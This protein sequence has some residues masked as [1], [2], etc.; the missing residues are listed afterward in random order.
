MGLKYVVILGDGMADY[1]V[2]SLGGKTPLAAAAIPHMDALAGAGILGLVQ[3]VPDG[4]AP[5]S[6]TANLAVLGYDPCA[7]FSGRSPFE[8]A[9]MG[10]ALGNEDITFRC[11]LVT[12]SEGDAYGERR[13]LDHSADE[14]STGE[15]REL[16]ES[17]RQ[18]FSDGDMTFYPG[19]SYRHLLVW[20]KG[21]R[22]WLLT[23]PHD[24]LGQAVQ[25]YLPAGPAAARV[26]QMM[27][28]SAVFL[29]RHPVNIERVRRGLRPANSIWIWGEGVKPQIPLFFEKYGIRGGVISAVDLIKGIGVCAGLDVIDVPGATGNLHTD[30]RGKA[31]AAL[32]A[33][34]EGLDFVY[35]HIEAPDEC[36]HRQETENKVKAIELIDS[37]TLKTLREG[38]D[39]MGEPYKILLLPDHATPLAVRTHTMDAV[40]F[41]IFDSRS[42]QPMVS[43]GYDEQ[44]AADAGLFIREGYRLMD[45]FLGKEVDK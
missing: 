4:M 36:G 1:P 33:L 32:D 43:R 11:N 28:E 42:S 29:P 15:A 5:G 37:L 24:I 20:H 26:L 12:I 14:I 19:V 9:S 16:I 41:V 8:A 3:T 27:E 7:Y 21:P 40:P 34:E 35:I 38:L 25:P 18:H 2:E 22:E 17:V 6:D 44:A 13:M 23:P 30:F 45:L 39:Q 10:V 31:Q